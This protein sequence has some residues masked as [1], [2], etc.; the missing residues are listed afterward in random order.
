M[1]I[2]ILVQLL[3]FAKTMSQSHRHVMCAIL[4]IFYRDSI[5]V[6]ILAGEKMH[7]LPRRT[8]VYRGKVMI[9]VV[10]LIGDTIRYDRLTCAQKLT[11]WPA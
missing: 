2:G 8:V 9:G 5:V 1:S 4:M 3:Q 7:S 6:I 11:R 10:S